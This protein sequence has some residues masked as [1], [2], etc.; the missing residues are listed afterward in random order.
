MIIMTF[1]RIQS[2]SIFS[3][4]TTTRAI[5]RYC[6]PA[7]SWSACHSSAASPT[8]YFSIHRPL[9]VSVLAPEW[10]CLLGHSRGEIKLVLRGQLLMF[11]CSFAWVQDAV[12]CRTPSRTGYNLWHCSR[13]YVTSQ[14]VSVENYVL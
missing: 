10:L 11:D 13:T 2:R 7:R 14:P 5:G 4:T 12:S 3:S 1:T 8:F 6:S 9:A